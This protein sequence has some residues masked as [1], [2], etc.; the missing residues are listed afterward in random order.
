MDLFYSSIGLVKKVNL[1]ETL[2]GQ[3]FSSIPQTR[4]VNKT[5]NDWSQDLSLGLCFIGTEKLLWRGV[6]F[7]CMRI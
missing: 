6:I 5:L 7:S 3:S 2:H 1:L 4:T